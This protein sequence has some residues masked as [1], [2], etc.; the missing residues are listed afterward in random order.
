MH[1]H[2][3]SLEQIVSV[4]LCKP[5]LCHFLLQ[6]TENEINM[7]AINKISKCFGWILVFLFLSHVPNNFVSKSDSIKYNSLADTA[8]VWEFG[9]WTPL[10]SG[11][12][13]LKLSF[14]W[15]RKFPPQVPNQW[16]AS[17]CTCHMSMKFRGKMMLCG[18]QMNYQHHSA[19]ISCRG[20]KDLRAWWTCC[21]FINLYIHVV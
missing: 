1:W 7:I 2:F 9:I 19:S 5:L 6:Q 13:H 12:F 17:T 11:L 14:D 20:T 15:N 4:G 3:L 18:R 8:V 16:D 21:L 10:P